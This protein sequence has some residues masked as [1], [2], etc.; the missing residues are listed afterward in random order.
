MKTM[1]LALLALPILTPAAHASEL[2]RYAVAIAATPVLNTPEFAKT[3]SGKVKLDPCKGVRPVEFVAFPGTLFRIEGEQETDGVK[4]YR[5]TTNDY[6]YPTKTGLFV[7][8]RF[9]EKV[10]GAPRERQRTLPEPAE[11]RKRLLA[12]VG[13]P[14]VWG[15]NFKEGVPLLRTLYPKGDPLYGVDCTGLLYEATDGYTPRN[16]SYLTRYGKGVKVA[17]L[18]AAEIAKKLEPLDLVVYRGHVM[19]VL[20]EDSIIQSV[21]GCGGGKRGVV[22]SPREETLKKL[23]RTREPADRYPKGSAGEK[24]FVVRRWLP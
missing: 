19:M 11:I 21:M 24:S 3:F 2:P 18:T 1:L 4:V 20:D 5:V 15:G 14:Y 16:S 8:A 22:V 6:P 12:A 9:L 10:E 13:R 17:G 23:M 7:D